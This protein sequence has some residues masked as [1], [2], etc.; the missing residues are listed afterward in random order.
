[1]P[2]SLWPLIHGTF[3]I[4]FVASCLITVVYISHQVL[5]SPESDNVRLGNDWCPSLYNQASPDDRNTEHNSLSK[6][7][8]PTMEVISP[9]AF[10]APHFTGFG[11]FGDLSLIM[12][13]ALLF[14]PAGDT[15]PDPAFAN[16]LPMRAAFTPATH[17][18]HPITSKKARNHP[19]TYHVAPQTRAKII[20]KT[21]WN[22]YRP[23]IEDLYVH[24]GLL[25]SQV[26]SRMA[27]DYGFN[28]R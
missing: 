28:A 9:F 18:H 10:Q 19:G 21:F 17:F 12:D 15:V 26:V 22:R 8:P 7:P 1:M 27:R 24:K 2:H 14:H 20:P 6:H 11:R 4:C 23:I 25:L 13:D 3:Y 5:S 16:V